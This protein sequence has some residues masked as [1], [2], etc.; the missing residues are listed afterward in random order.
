MEDFGL[1]KESLASGRYHQTLRNEVDA[2]FLSPAPLSAHQSCDGAGGTDVRLAD[3]L[4][5]PRRIDGG[6]WI[7][8]SE[9]RLAVAEVDGDDRHGLPSE[10]AWSPGCDHRGDPCI[11]EPWVEEVRAVHRTSEPR[12]HE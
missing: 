8:R 6:Y 1:D 11:P 3:T 4:D 12:L 7:L 2:R 10:S 5:A 9:R